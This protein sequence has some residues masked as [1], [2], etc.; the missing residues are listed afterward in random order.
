MKGRL[1]YRFQLLADDLLSD[2]VAQSGYPKFT[3]AAIGLGYFYLLYCR[4][5]ITAAG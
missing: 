1:H 3:D 5:H 4:R 2:A